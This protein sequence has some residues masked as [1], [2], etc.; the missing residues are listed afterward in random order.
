MSLFVN[1]TQ[2]AN[3]THLTKARLLELEDILQSDDDLA[4]ADLIQIGNELLG[5]SQSAMHETN[6]QRILAMLEAGKVR[7]MREVQNV[8]LEHVER[9]LAAKQGGKR[10]AK[11]TKRRRKTTRR[12]RKTL[13]A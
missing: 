2:L 13:K 4:S 6:L 7:R 1:T 9:A 8:F 3:I 11:Q 10:Q 5:A 12:K